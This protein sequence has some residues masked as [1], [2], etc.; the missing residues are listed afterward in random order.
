MRKLV[1]SPKFKRSL[2]RYLKRNNK[3]Q[4]QAESTLMLLQGDI[5]ASKLE[6]HP[7]QGVLADL[8]ACSCGY[9]CR[10][11]F[12]LEDEQIILLDVGTH[13]EVY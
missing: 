5:V 1:P 3:F 2:R 10:I 6:T 8:F 9:D 7:L 13:D 11:I 4:K 12:S